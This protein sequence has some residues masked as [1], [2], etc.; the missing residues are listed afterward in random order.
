M[1]TDYLKTIGFKPVPQTD[2]EGWFYDP[3]YL[4]K[5]GLYAEIHDDNQFY[6]WY[7]V[8]NPIY[9]ATITTEN[10]LTVKLKVIETLSRYGLSIKVTN[11]KTL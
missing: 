11:G 3:D 5:E 2:R 1:I 9:E 6:L 8:F 4:C 10:L 7:D